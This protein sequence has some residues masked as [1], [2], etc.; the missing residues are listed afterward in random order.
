MS[1]ITYERDP[2][3]QIPRRERKSHLARLDW[4]LLLAAL[5]LSCLGVALVWSATLKTDDG[6]SGRRQAISLVVALALAYLIS[7]ANTRWL[8][9]FAIPAYVL[10]LIGLLATFTPL[11]VEVAGARAWV[12][13]PGGFTLQPSEF[14]KVALILTIGAILSSSGRE[15]GDR[16]GF[17]PVALSIA[18]A[19][20]PAGIV[21]LQSDTGSAMVMGCVLAVMLLV[22]G[23]S[24]FIL[25]PIALIIGGG[26]YYVLTNDVLPDYQMARLTAFMNP[27]A[28]P[29]G[30]GHNTLQSRIAIGAGGMSGQGL[31]Q[32]MQTQ[33]GFVPV[34][35][36]DFI[37][38]VAVEELG[39]IGGVVLIFLLCVILLRGVQ[40]AFRS[41]RVFSRCVAGGIVAWFAF[42]G[43]ESIGMALGITPVTGVTLP[44]V[45]YGGTSMIA[46]WLA[47][48]ILQAIRIS[49]RRERLQ[50]EQR[51]DAPEPDPRPPDQDAATAALPRQADAPDLETAQPVAPAGEPQS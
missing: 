26:V 3:L 33:G 40:I 24:W 4:I 32:G 6:M 37:Y 25:L 46:T 20:P 51:T 19:L 1:V 8:R 29:L 18:V 15:Y 13:L 22:A 45:S 10:A 28:D 35:E 7:R 41:K 21:I 39:F 14:A 48:G 23:T 31:G 47:V 38:T 44:F 11:G 9:R 43:F 30:A 2:D 34:N 36:S 42:Q 49:E 50:G 5:A 12:Q 27:E 17:W 16:P